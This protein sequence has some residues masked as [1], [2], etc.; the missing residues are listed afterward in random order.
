MEYI[1]I[2]EISKKWNMKE[3]KVTAFCRDGRIAGA[4]KNGKG[5]LI[6]SDAVKP[7]D[8]RTK[9]FEEFTLSLEEEKTTVSYTPTGG[10]AKVIASYKTI[11]KRKP[12]YT[13][14]TPYRLCLLGINYDY[15]KGGILGLTLDKGIHM[16][17]S[18]KDNGIIELFSLQYPK[19]AQW[20]VIDP[21][22]KPQGDWADP[23]RT[24]ATELNKRYALRM[25]ISAVIDGEL[26]I[27][28]ISC[29]NSLIIT[30]LSALAFAN[31][32]K[33]SIEELIEI[34][35]LTDMTYKIT[36]NTKADSLLEIYSKKNKLMHID[37]KDYLYQLLDT[38]SK[39][40]IVIFFSGLE[41]DYNL[42]MYN[43]RTEELKTTSYMIKAFNKDNYTIVKDS[44]LREIP[45]EMFD[46]YKSKLPRNFV[47]RSE[48]W[49]SEQQRIK[50]GIKYYEKGDIK[51]FGKLLTESG[52][53][54][55]NNWETGSKEMID[56]FSIIKEQK[57]VYGT[58]FSGSGFK[59]CCIA[60]TDP[61]YTKEIIEKVKEEYTKKYPKLKNKYSSHI[62]TSADGV[63]L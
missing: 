11:Y 29:S 20:H 49:Y 28:G 56:L 44:N 10:E 55:I 31:K 40:D 59:R 17:Y 38:K 21:P 4:R 30:F 47:K 15:N 8:K 9:E 36:T 27:D 53:S 16:G 6:P 26:P 22:Q 61:K 7:L 57:G 32:I 51:S 48:H 14:F 42:T 63:K 46:K 1:S 33:L 25:G 45:Y 19:R 41:N 23:L 37:T 39:Y 3:R 18:L 24:A 13:T 60:L 34:A 5:W 62:C 50:E 43:T 2:R 52:I 12:D 35:K 58:R 54:S